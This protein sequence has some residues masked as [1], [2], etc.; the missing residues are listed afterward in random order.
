MVPQHI[1]GTNDAFDHPQPADTAP[2]RTLEQGQAGRPKAAIQAPGDLGHPDSPGDL[3]PDPG[4]RLVQFGHRQ[5]VTWMRSR[6]GWRTRPWQVTA[7]CS[8]V[9]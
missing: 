7:I 4:T 5:Q 2:S 3:T 1:G 9:G 8:Q 6:N